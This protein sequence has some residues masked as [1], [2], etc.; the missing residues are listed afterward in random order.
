MSETRLAQVERRVSELE[1][2]NRRLRKRMEQ[3]LSRKGGHLEG[4]LHV[5]GW[6]QFEEQAT[7]VTPATDLARLGI[8]DVG[9]V[10]QM[11]VMFSNGT[12]VPIAQE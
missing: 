3:L 6:L 12:I 7:I 4:Q 9:G 1:E 11:V 5:D 8:V 2:Q 10:Q